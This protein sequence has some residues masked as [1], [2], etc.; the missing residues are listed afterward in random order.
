MDSAAIRA[1]N[2]T[3]STILRSIKPDATNL[4][5]WWTSILNLQIEPSTSMQVA[6][7]LISIQ[8]PT[9]ACVAT[10]S[11]DVTEVS[12]ESKC[13]ASAAVQ[14]PS[15]ILINVGVANIGK[16]FRAWATEVSAGRTVRDAIPMAPRTNSEFTSTNLVGN[17]F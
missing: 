9:D 5:P 3:R 12:H 6:L 14:A 7:S 4:V 13:S 10:S 17:L 8:T 2:E 15:K 11:C 16:S 1:A